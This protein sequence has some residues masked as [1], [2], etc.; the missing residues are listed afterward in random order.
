MHR[1][2]GAIVGVL[3]A[4][5]AAA[6]VTASAA[7]KTVFAGPSAAQQKQ[8]QKLLGRKFLNAYNPDADAFF[9]QRVTIHTG[10]SVSFQINGFHDIDL[11]G[12]SGK[13]LPTI[14]PSGGLVS[15][16]KDFAGNPF[17]FNGKVP[18]LGLNPA[19]LTPSGPKT[20]DGTNRILSGLPLGPPKPLKVTFTKAGTYKFYCDIHPG[21]VGFVVVK[22]HGR[23]VPSAKQDAA[24]RDREFRQYVKT[25]ARLAHR[26][27]AKLTVSLGEAGPGGAE[28]FQMFPNRLRVKAGSVVTFSMSPGTFEAHTATFG[29]AGYLKNLAAGLFRSPS[30]TQI[31]AYPSSPGQPIPLAPNSHGN[32][33]ANTGT[34]DRDRNTPVGPT[35]RIRFT[36]A[37]TYHF[38]CVIHPDMKGTIV[39]T[40]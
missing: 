36:K 6:P 34:L 24:E 20:Y 14:L 15:G 39:V 11:P 2:V 3:A 40:K 28:L 16:V 8:A 10:D 38:I 27:V 19:L 31:S 32:G 4:A 30:P 33:F 23:A 22:P 26:R 1:R 37:G 35:S 17:W 18:S 7:T 13:G 21:M 12:E 29:P 5:A 25:F 9:S